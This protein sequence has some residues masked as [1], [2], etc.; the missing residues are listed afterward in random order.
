MYRARF[1]RVL[2][3]TAALS[4]GVAACAQNTSQKPGDET[5]TSGTGSAPSI[6]A[7]PAPEVP[8]NAALPAGDGKAKCGK[9]S[10]A[11]IGTIAG[12]SAALGLNILNGVKLAVKEHNDANPGCQVTL[13]QFDSE[14][15]PDKAPGVVTQAISDPTILG[16]VGLAFSGESKAVGKSFNDAGLVTISPSATNPGLS[17]NGWK[18]F[19]RALGNDAVQGPAISAFV[20]NELNAKKVCVVRDDSEYGIGLADQTSQA[21]GSKVVCD[22]QVKTAQKEFSAVVGAVQAA[23]PD[24]V[25]YAGYYPEAAPF[26]QQ[27]RDAGYEG[28]VVAPD[29]VRDD[30]FVKNAG[31]AAEG[32]YLSCPC[33]PSSGFTKFSQDYKALSNREPSTYSPEGYDATTILLQGI[34]KGLKDRASLLNFVKTY[35]GQGLTKQFKWDGKG[36]LTQTP[37]WIY[38]VKDGKIVQLKDMSKS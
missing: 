7:D 31:E 18:T 15:S 20:A 27:L 26:V 29:G 33:L 22:E 17:T 12:A 16:V 6:K 9:V 24:A 8:A 36:E 3:L 19:F 35:E 13:K 4:L 32:V 1:V 38:E 11:Y 37:V 34:D 5:K 25:F 2:A 28:A 30:E 10:I 21:L 14:G 23:S